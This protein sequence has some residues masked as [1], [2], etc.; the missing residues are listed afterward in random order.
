MFWSAFHLP[1]S[2]QFFNTSDSAPKTMSLNHIQAPA[3][4]FALVR[5]VLCL[6][7]ECFQI[8]SPVPYCQKIY[9]LRHQGLSE[10][11]SFQ[12]F[13]PSPKHLKCP[14]PP[15]GQNQGDCRCLP[16][17]LPP[18][19]YCM[20][21]LHMPGLVCVL[22]TAV[23]LVYI[24]ALLLFI[25]SVFFLPAGNPFSAQMLAVVPFDLVFRKFPSNQWWHSSDFGH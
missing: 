19:R 16:S 22:P 10:Y 7:L 15:M 20:L 24:A 2:Y 11:I 21:K 25:S 9:S 14:W 17:P 5:N 6:F 8:V 23:S 3:I 18:G 4:A 13:Q 12:Y 1:Q